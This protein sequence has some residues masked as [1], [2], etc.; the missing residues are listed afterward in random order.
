[1]VDAKRNGGARRR[2]DR[3]LDVEPGL[4]ER[5]IENTGGVV[6]RVYPEHI[7]AWLHIPLQG[8]SSVDAWR[9]IAQQ[10]GKRDAHARPARPRRDW[11]GAVDFEEYG[12]SAAQVELAAP[13]LPRPDAWRVRGE[14]RALALLETGENR[15]RRQLIA[16]FAG[17]AD[18]DEMRAARVD[19]Q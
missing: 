5:E 15:C 6:D 2:C 12:R 10:R 19:T 9:G 17:D 3:N 11:T 18:H 4:A 7:P 8:H 1:V 13:H 14:N 16:A